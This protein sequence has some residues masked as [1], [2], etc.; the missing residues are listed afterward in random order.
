MGLVWEC[1][2]A[3]IIDGGAVILAAG[4]R[5]I[6]LCWRLMCL[7][8]FQNISLHNNVVNYSINARKIISV[9]EI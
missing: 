5:K 3:L 9:T 7:S 8:A 6:G 1:A 2:G 4:G